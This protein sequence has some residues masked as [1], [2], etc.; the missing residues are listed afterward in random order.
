MEAD[1]F[2]AWLR[3]PMRRA[4]EV[5]RVPPG[6]R[7]HLQDRLL[8]SGLARV[9]AARRGG[10]MWRGREVYWPRPGAADLGVL[11]LPVPGPGEVLVRPVFT[12]VS[13][14][15]ER[16]LL[17]LLPGITAKF[18][19]R[20]GYSGA[21]TVIQVGPGV[22][23]LR[24]GDRVA[25]GETI[26]HASL[27]LVRQDRVF[28]IST[29]LEFEE[30]AFLHLLVIVQQG[31]RKGHL[32]PGERLTVIGAGLLG[33]LAVQ[34]GRCWGASEIAVMA[35][36]SAKRE[37]ALRSG[38][39]RFIDLER[40]GVEVNAPGADVVI[41]VTGSPEAL[42]VAAQAARPG[43]R[44][45]LLGSTRGI[46]R[47]VDFDTLLRRRELVLIGAHIST[48]PDVPTAA[49]P[50]TYGEEAR[51]V[52]S[53]LE[54]RQVRPSLLVQE[55]V[56]PRE[57]ALFY[58][59]LCRG[60]RE[61]VGAVFDWGRLAEQ[62]R[63][64]RSFVLL[65]PRDLLRKGRAY[66][67]NDG[68]P[69]VLSRPLPW[70]TEGLDTLPATN[71]VLRFALIGCGGMGAR[72]AQAL[73][74]AP[75]TRLVATMDP[76]AA[77]AAELAGEAF[78]TT[79]LDEVLARPDVD[80][81]LIATPNHLHHPVGI[82]AARAGKHIVMEKPLAHDLAHADDLV[83]ACRAAGVALSVGYSFRYAP[84]IRAARRLV[85][86]GLVGRILSVQLACYWD[87]PPSYYGSG[88]THRTHS[89]WRGRRDQAGGGVMMMNMSHQLDQVRYIVGQDVTQVT[90]LEGALDVPAGVK[91]EDVIS[92]ACVFE[93]GAVGSFFGACF[94]RGLENQIDLRIIGD[95]G[96]IV[97]E[98]PYRFYTYRAAPGVVPG[99]W[100]RFGKLP[101]VDV[102]A[103]YLAW[104][105]DAVLTGRCPEVD[106]A[107][108]RAVQAWMEAIY[109]AA[110]SGRAVT[111]SATAPI[112]SPA[113]G[114][115]R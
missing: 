87:K 57:A 45:V 5:A 23:G 90:A 14:G 7:P 65:P 33:L 76:N 79:R 69:S 110:D 25:C 8:R 9:R 32:Q 85:E 42:P 41:E 59:R 111:V 91:V 78:S 88:Y 100:H 70:L 105:A 21:G 73:R 27:A 50:Y 20:P 36:S 62:E 43:G 34:L 19:L 108:G 94:A 12:A 64:R 15:T 18:P 48:V 24:P 102:H 84:E 10:R 30:A 28:S 72:H 46:N 99:R 4:M 13:P 107:A 38:A 17:N 89:D 101:A 80:A 96:T 82:A 1:G 55:R 2:K 98:R 113:L 83:A 35:A 71:G 81:V 63:C 37:L 115:V 74:T 109:E 26:P 103:A 68:P 86:A 77:L 6:V 3:G 11:E 112:A 92:V 47:G 61:I 56:D 114:K 44:V 53:L 16:A 60:E 51:A 75:N 93:G 58:R 66:D 29:V 40:S 95:A 104:F 67:Q 49:T 31:I 39:V 106:G 54:E 22:T 97:L 52:L